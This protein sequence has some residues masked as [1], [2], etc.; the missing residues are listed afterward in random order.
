MAPLPSVQTVAPVPAVR[1]KRTP[2]VAKEDRKSTGWWVAGSAF[3]AAS[4]ASGVG[5][6]LETRA[7]N[8]A[9]SIPQPNNRVGNARTGQGIM[10]TTG[11]LGIASLGVAVVR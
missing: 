6:L 2:K 11:A 9:T 1:A 7:A 10:F 4:A 8:E 5:A 3:M